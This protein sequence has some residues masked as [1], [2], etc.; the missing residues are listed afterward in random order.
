MS[1]P[2]QALSTNKLYQPVKNQLSQVGTMFL[3]FTS[4]PSPVGTLCQIFR[5][6]LYQMGT[7]SINLQM[8][9]SHQPKLLKTNIHQWHLVRMPILR[10]F[11]TK[12][13]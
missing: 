2:A 6:P 10:L 9:T 12:P 8:S 4:K 13:P 11:L 1:S 5:S 3:I 7:N